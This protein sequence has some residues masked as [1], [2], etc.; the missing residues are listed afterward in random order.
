[1]ILR[2]RQPLSLCVREGVCKPLSQ[3]LPTF[4]DSSSKPCSRQGPLINLSR[5]T[6]DYAIRTSVTMQPLCELYETE[7]NA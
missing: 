6:T 7:V 4:R 5:W 2:A 1:M 3:L